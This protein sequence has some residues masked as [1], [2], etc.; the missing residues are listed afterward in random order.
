[1]ASDYVQG[2][3]Y[4]GYN[5]PGV[6]GNGNYQ[7]YTYDT[8]AG[9]GNWKGSACLTENTDGTLTF[10][11]FDANQLA[12]VWSESFQFTFNATGGVLDASLTQSNNVGLVTYV[13]GNGGDW[14]LG[15]YCLWNSSQRVVPS[16]F[17]Q[18]T[19]NGVKCFRALLHPKPSSGTLT[20][21]MTVS[22]T[23]VNH[24]E[25]GKGGN[26][27]LYDGTG[28]GATLTLKGVPPPPAT[29]TSVAP[30]PSDRLTTITLS[31]TNL[32]PN[33]RPYFGSLSNP[34]PSWTAVNPTTMTAQV[35]NMAPGATT[36][37][38][39]D[40]NNT[41]NAL[42][43]TVNANVLRG[44][45]SGETAVL[46]P[47]PVTIPPPAT[48]VAITVT[49]AQQ[50]LVEGASAQF[51][52]TGTYSDG[53]TK[54]L[55]GATWSVSNLSGSGSIDPSSGFFVAHV[56]GS[57]VV[58]TATLGAVAGTASVI[59]AQQ[60]I[61]PAKLDT[62]STTPNNPS[63]VLGK[64]LQ[65]HASGLQTVYSDVQGQIV[66]SQVTVYP[67]VTWTV[68]NHTGKGTIETSAYI[69]AVGYLIAPLS[70]SYT[71]GLNYAG[72]AN[73]FLNGQIIISD[74]HGTQPGSAGTVYSK[75]GT[76]QLKAG[77]RYP[78]VIE[79]AGATSSTGCE[80]LWTPP[81]AATGLVPVTA[82]ECDTGAGATVTVTA[83]AKDGSGLQ[84]SQTVT[85]V[86]TPPP[87]APPAGLVSIAVSPKQATVAAGQTLQFSAQGFDE[88][89]EPYPIAVT[90][91][92]VCGAGAATIDPHSG[93]LKGE[94]AGGNITV[95][96][97]TTDPSQL[98]DSAAVTVVAGPL[99]KLAVTPAATLLQ[100]GQGQQF[101]AT[102]YDSY[103]NVKL[104]GT[105]LWTMAGGTGT[106]SQSGLFSATN[107]GV[108]K[109][110]ASI[111]NLSAA[112]TTNVQAVVGG[113]TAKTAVQ[114]P[115]ARI[116]LRDTL[117]APLVI[118]TR[119]R[120]GGLRAEASLELGDD[121]WWDLTSFDGAPFA[122]YGVFA[123]H[124]LVPT[125][126]GQIAS[127][128]ASKLLVQ[129]V[130]SKYAAPHFLGL[131]TPE[132][133]IPRNPAYL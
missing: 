95:T 22:L 63:V 14:T 52:A 37:F 73:L 115:F 122:M 93:L 57:N 54:P 105:V 20:A 74:L 72:G 129:D 68:L 84:S 80:L 58:V 97:T 89:G 106:V 50:K 86:G 70:G 62:L 56:A 6:T 27:N 71:I 113:V 60:P 119:V 66:S 34:A 10:W 18:V 110:I 64:Q 69:R 124:V 77:Q 120:G 39:S 88:Y 53:S 45:Y 31:G 32:G 130:F 21:G 76:L 17:D 26:L 36:V 107:P 28:N 40:G 118:D 98:H 114:Q 65:F 67:P 100:V 78:I 24:F 41:S 23:A 79:Y 7:T 51:S 75:S 133:S 46:F 11:M 1:M 12:N 59:I 82:L 121:F 15:S 131:V 55:A 92:I 117:A 5:Y 35:P 30:N 108:G 104:L 125:P 33:Y 81:S 94:I 111:S 127:A 109:V 48:L 2:Y 9:N 61:P 49:P 43:F 42:A 8:D 3:E 83:T 87:A 103:G 112:A 25:N 116:H 44:P 4:L 85:I 132:T 19:I 90:W 101:T 96:A 38:V 99:V 91:S 47:A 102:G 29:L 123:A 128:D 13:G 126:A 16:T